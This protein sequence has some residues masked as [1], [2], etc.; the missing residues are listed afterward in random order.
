MNASNM[1][2]PDLAAKAPDTTG[3]VFPSLTQLQKA[4]ELITKNWDRV[5]ALDIH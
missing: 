2:P 3:T 5:V 1:V 4:T